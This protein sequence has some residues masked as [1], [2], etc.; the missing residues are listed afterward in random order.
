MPANAL[1]S[2]LRCST[3]PL[4]LRQISP[5]LARKHLKA[6]GPA[7][8]PPPLRS[9]SARPG[10]P[11]GSRNPQRRDLSRNSALPEPSGSSGD[12]TGFEDQYIGAFSQSYENLHQ[13]IQDPET[14]GPRI[15]R[16]YHAVLPSDTVY[17]TVQIPAHSEPC[18]D[19]DLDDIGTVLPPAFRDKEPSHVRIAYLQAVISNV[20]RNMP[21]IDTTDNLNIILNAFDAAG[22]LPDIP[23]P[24]RTLVSAKRRLG[25][26]PDQWIVQYAICPRCWKHYS[27]KELRELT[28]PGCLAPGCQ[29]TIYTEKRDSKGSLKRHPITIMPQVSLIQNLRRMVRRKGFR[30][31][32]RDNRNTPTNQNDDDNFV[33]KDMYDGTLWHD[34][35]TK[36]KR[37]VGNFGT[38]R[39]M[40]I[41]EDG[42]EHR[43]TETRFGL[44][45][46]INIDW[47][48]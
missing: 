25:I 31:L 1:C 30:K 6:Y 34:L 19:E 24:V 3:K 41:G 11:S 21:V 4:L 48:V 37:E 2:C 8:L 16:E 29:E 28:G 15:H 45:L 43:L 13:I 44:H 23:R 5:N 9:A 39:D 27:P 20:Y 33:M 26:D 38:V 17:R 22:V 35:K 46:V 32:I 36:I 7:P 18:S 42:V 40:P 47:Y 12:T 14:S 10:L